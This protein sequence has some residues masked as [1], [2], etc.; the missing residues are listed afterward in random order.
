VAS[1]VAAVGLTVG[2]Q[3]EHSKGLAARASNTEN[4]YGRLATYEQGIQIFRSAPIVGIGVDRYHDVSEQRDPVRVSGVESITYPHN[5]YIGLLAEQG[6]VGF[7][8][9]LVVTYAVWNLVR[10]F[11]AMSRQHEDIVLGATLTGAVMGYLI[12]S[13]TLTM[14]PYEPSNTFLAAFLGA[15]SARLDLLRTAAE[16]RSP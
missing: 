3:L 6:L 11:R 12:M 5:S 1:L 8:P 15:A 10:T 14:L 2:A 16:P 7:L 4:I 13:L 9:L